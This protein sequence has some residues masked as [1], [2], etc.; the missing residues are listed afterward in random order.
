MSRKN[1]L[2]VSLYSL[3]ISVVIFVINYFFFHFVTD[4]GITTTWH[5]EAG[6]PFVAD[7]I[8]QLGVLMLFFSIAT[9][10]IGLICYKKED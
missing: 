10:M 6:K 8:G 5:P 4:D 3:I 9:L 2:K 1:L 7:L